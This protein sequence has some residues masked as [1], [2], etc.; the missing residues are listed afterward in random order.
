VLSDTKSIEDKMLDVLRN[1]SELVDFEGVYIK[2]GISAA[3]KQFPFV[4][5]GNMRYREGVLK[6]AGGTLIYA[7][8]IY[9][10]ARNMV[11]GRAF[12][13]SEQGKGV[14]NIC[15]AVVR[16]IKN[17]DFEKIFIKPVKNIKIDPIYMVDGSGMI[18]IGEVSFEAEVWYH[19]ERI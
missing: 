2:G 4:A 15:S 14:G 13:D 3:I 9:V 1:S 11:S 16:T 17:S 6:D 18:C 5:L 8:S 19:N 12:N 10:G 7:V